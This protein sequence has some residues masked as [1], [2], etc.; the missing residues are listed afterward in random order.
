MCVCITYKYTGKP[1]QFH[2]VQPKN[3]CMLETTCTY[4]N[5]QLPNTFGTLFIKMYACY[6]VD[7]LSIGYFCAPSTGCFYSLQNHTS[8]HFNSLKHLRLVS[9]PNT[10]EAYDLDV[11]KRR[12][13]R[14]AFLAFVWLVRWLHQPKY[15]NRA[16]VPIVNDLK[17]LYLTFIL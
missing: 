4:S 11:L 13:G 9:V 2:T 16:Q 10:P 7:K 6:N 3:G 1:K 12:R 15:S 5:I 8:K 14:C 17:L